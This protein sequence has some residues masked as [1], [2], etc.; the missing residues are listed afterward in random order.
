MKKLT[1]S[2]AAALALGT[3][4]APAAHATC[5]PVYDPGSA[6]PGKFVLRPDT[7]VGSE[8]YAEGQFA[9]ELSVVLRK[10]TFV[11]DTADDGL[12]A[13]LWVLYGPWN[14]TKHKEP[15]AVASGPGA[16][17]DV[18]WVSPPG[19]SVT[20]FQIRV[21]LGPGEVTCSRWVG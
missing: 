14:G 17:T 16:Q 6:C 4:V 11:K 13:Y 5:D 8:A 3:L 7:P 18:E 21:C 20:Q 9:T 1:V 15:I 12:D 2:M 19:V 10:P